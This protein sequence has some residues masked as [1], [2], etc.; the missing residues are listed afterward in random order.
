MSY[1]LVL[2]AVAAVGIVGVEVVRRAISG[3]RL[4]RSFDALRTLGN[5]IESSLAQRTPDVATYGLGNY[6]QSLDP[7]KAAAATTVRRVS[8]AS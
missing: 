5:T 8:R 3:R 1:F 6:P 4:E 2:I 7:A